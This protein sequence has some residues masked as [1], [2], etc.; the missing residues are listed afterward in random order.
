MART[1]LPPRGPQLEL[2]GALSLAFVNTAAARKK[3]RQQGIRTY[4]ELLVWSQQTGVLQ[5]AGAARLAQLAAELPDAATATYA[6][7]EALRAGMARLFLAI[8]HEKALPEG[9]LRLF[10]E[11]LAEAL[12]AL[13]LVPGEAGPTWGWAGDENALDRMLWPVLHAAG[14]LLISTGGRPQVRQCAFSE[15][16]LFFVDRTPSGRRRWCEMEN[17]GNRVKALRHYRRTRRSAREKTKRNLGIWR[18]QR[19]RPSKIKL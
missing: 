11:G 8:Q 5:A 15:C 2:A 16:A 9:D 17:C 18:A 1:N 10:N 12:P 6:R 3:N 19:P 14:E 7:A 13:R 4:A